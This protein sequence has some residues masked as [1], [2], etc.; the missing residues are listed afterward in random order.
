MISEFSGQIPIL[1]VC[2]G[3]QCIS[4]VYGAE[5]VRGSRIMHGKVSPIYHNGENIFKGVSSPFSATRYHS[6]LVKPDTLKEPLELTAWTEDNEIMSTYLSSG[7]QSKSE[8]LQLSFN[9][10]PRIFLSDC[11]KEFF[12]IFMCLSLCDSLFRASCFS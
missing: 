4:E 9:L 12:L 7:L 8:A 3:H 1:G 10:K 6:L 2:L 5:I 11:V